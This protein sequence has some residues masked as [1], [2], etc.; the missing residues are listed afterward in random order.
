MNRRNVVA[1]V[2]CFV[3]VAALAAAV[4][5]RPT[6]VADLP[7][8]VAENIA[9]SGASHAI[10]SVLLDFRSYDTLLEIAVL[11]VAVVVAL[12]L[13]E[14]QL[15]GADR[16]G[17]ANPLLRA[18]MSW[19]VPLMLLVAAYLLWAGSSRTGG[20][21]QAGAVLAAAGVSLRLAG[22]RLAWMEHQALTRVLL[23]L[24]L[25]CFVGVGSVLLALG[26]GYLD[27]PQ[28]WAGGLILTIE[29]AL[30]VSIAL[31]LLSLFRLAPPAEDDTLPDRRG[32]RR[33]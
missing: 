1:A 17:L 5:L 19:L 10:T 3:L 4:G 23:A 16:M 26:R 29:T 12:A 2:V 28:A 6:Q 31:A 22:V 20:A 27:Y 13:Q 9:D 30:T 32:R 14:A 33:E 11:L 25:A 24:G 7:T 21:F 15:D 18:V 8:L